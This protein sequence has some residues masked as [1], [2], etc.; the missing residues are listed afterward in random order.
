MHSFMLQY[1]VQNVK[2]MF[3][4]IILSQILPVFCHKNNNIEIELQYEIDGSYENLRFRNIRP[5]PQ[6][7][8]DDDAALTLVPDIES[9]IGNPHD[10]NIGSFVNRRINV[11]NDNCHL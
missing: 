11:S 8:P 4:T 2:K 7:A 3:V 10:K 5:I 1:Q 6:D 9:A